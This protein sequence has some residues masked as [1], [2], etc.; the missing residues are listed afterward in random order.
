[1]PDLRDPAVVYACY[2]EETGESGTYHLQGYIELKY[3]YS[4]QGVKGLVK[5]LRGAHL[6]PRR[7]TADEA[8]DYCRKP[9]GWGFYEHGEFRGNARRFDHLDDFETWAILENCHKGEGDFCNKPMLKCILIHE[10]LLMQ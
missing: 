7:G 1:M 4:M 6:E 3:A 2:Q 9:G 10:K 8:R 5:G